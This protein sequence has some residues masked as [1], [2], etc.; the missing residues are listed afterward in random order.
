MSFSQTRNHDR[1]LEYFGSLTERRCHSDLTAGLTL[2]DAIDMVTFYLSVLKPFTRHYSVWA[3]CNLAKEP[4]A[5]HTKI[6][7]GLSE[8]EEHRIIRALYRF[9]LCSN[10]FGMGP[11]KDELDLFRKEFQLSDSDILKLLEDLWE[12]WE[13]EEI[14]CINVFVETKCRAIHDAVTWDFSEKNPRFDD[15]ERPPT[16]EGAVNIPRQ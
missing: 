7:E 10:V 9:Q 13:L 3:L 14:N 11:N 8:S 4:E 2:N 16:P 6:D 1:I 12:P 5:T 15:Q